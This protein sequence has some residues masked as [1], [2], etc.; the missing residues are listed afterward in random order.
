MAHRMLFLSGQ[1]AID[2]KTHQKIKG[3]VQNE[4]DQVMQNIKHVLEAAHMG[5]QNVVKTTIFVSDLKNYHAVNE[6]YAHYFKN[7][8][9][10]RSAVQ[11][12][13]LPLDAQVE[14]EMIAYR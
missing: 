13:S 1:I 4:T 9:P 11:V 12:S 7:Q 6:I 3:G 2:P 5:F 8:P 14:I 10:A